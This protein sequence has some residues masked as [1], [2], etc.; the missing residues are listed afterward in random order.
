MARPVLPPAPDK[1][2]S[3]GIDS[4]FATTMPSD[5]R[6][7]SAVAAS[8]CMGE[9]S[10]ESSATSEGVMHEARETAQ[11]VAGVFSTSVL[12]PL[13][14]GAG[15]AEPTLEEAAIRFANGDDGGAESLP[16]AALHPGK[17]PPATSTKNPA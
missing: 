14:A 17:T 2:P 5:L 12:E 11:T 3:H 16:S 6:T 15:L 4:A 9:T 7:Y 13:H 10:Q 8:T 1:A